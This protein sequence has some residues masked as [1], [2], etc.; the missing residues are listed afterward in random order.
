MCQ[1]VEIL[2]QKVQKSL[3]FNEILELIS[4]LIGSH[5]YIALNIAASA[6]ESPVV[7]RA[8][9]ATR[10][11]RLINGQSLTPTKLNDSPGSHWQ[12]CRICPK[13]SGGVESIYR[14]KSVG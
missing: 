10:S 13:K 14:L 7:H 11:A 4:T 8:S 1:F 9:E 6:V 3:F 12:Q 2:N 5:L